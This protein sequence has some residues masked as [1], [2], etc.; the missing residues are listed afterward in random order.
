MRTIFLTV[1]LL[2]AT[3]VMAQHPRALVT[4]ADIDFIRAKISAGEQPWTSQYA[5]LITRANAAKTAAMEYVTSG[6]ETPTSPWTNNDFYTSGDGGGDYTV[7]GKMGNAVM[8]LAFAYQL[9][10]NNDPSYSD[11]CIKILKAWMVTP[12]TRMRPRYTNTGVAIEVVTTVPSL[13][14]A[15]D[16]VYAAPQMD[17]TTLNGIRSWSD[18]MGAA[19]LSEALKTAASSINGNMRHYNNF[20]MWISNVAA[21]AS[22]ITDGSSMRTAALGQYKMNIDSFFVGADSVYPKHAMTSSGS[23]E[24]NP[25]YRYVNSVKTYYVPGML[26]SEIWRDQ[27]LFYSHYALKAMITSAWILGPEAYGYV[28][29]RGQ[30]LR[31]SFQWYRRY[32]LD[33]SDIWRSGKNANGTNNV[34]GGVLQKY[35]QCDEVT[36]FDCVDPAKR[37]AGREA[38]VYVIAHKIWP[39]DG[40][41]T[42]VNGYWKSA[43][44][45]PSPYYTWE[46]I[47]LIG[48]TTLAFSGPGQTVAAAEEEELPLEIRL[49]QNYPNPFNPST[50]IRYDLPSA[51]RVRLVVFNAIGQEVAILVDEEK[52]VGKHELQ[53]N[54]IGLASGMYFYRITVGAFSSVQKMAFAK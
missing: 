20:R 17:A 33:K 21:I 24:N 31:K 5:T 28:G 22:V 34:I 12:A 16:L 41:E 4:Q 35:R 49:H 52:P 54:A 27:G 8:D 53:F 47:R 19:S 25:R 7:A 40:F 48:P 23:S 18:S 39:N 29:P 38:D 46:D 30:S 43:Y 50:T 26:P 36:S 37:V 6:G 15:A 10:P 2:L 1:V 51:A 3:T 14:L 11:K 13:M 32:M 44:H 45:A 42:V 9:T